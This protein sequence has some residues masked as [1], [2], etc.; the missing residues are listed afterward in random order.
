M[1]MFLQSLVYHHDSKQ[2]L[3]N[4]E[5]FVDRADAHGMK[6]MPVLFDSCFGV[7]PSLESQHVWVA[8]PGPDRM[9]REFWPESEK[10]VREV[11]S[12]FADDPWISFW[13]VM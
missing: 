5:H 6:V 1:R 13:D 7:S 12:R 4:L 3:N 8:N 10:Y 9:G 2:F 11:V